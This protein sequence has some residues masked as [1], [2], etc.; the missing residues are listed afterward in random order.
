MSTQ[1]QRRERTEIAAAYTPHPTQW[2]SVC[3]PLNKPLVVV[4]FST[5]DEAMTHAKRRDGV[6]IVPDSHRREPWDTVAT[7]GS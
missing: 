4:N 7:V 3:D 6:V 2:K 1:K 5:R